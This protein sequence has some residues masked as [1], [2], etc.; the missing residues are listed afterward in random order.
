MT[1]ERLGDQAMIR[2]Q[3][4]EAAEIF[5]GAKKGVNDISVLIRLNR[6]LLRCNRY[7]AIQI[8]GVKCQ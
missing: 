3:W 8:L 7:V 4:S 5:D 2:Q 6:K 1:P